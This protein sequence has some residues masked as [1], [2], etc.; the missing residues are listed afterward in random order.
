MAWILICGIAGY[1]FSEAAMALYKSPLAA[2]PLWGRLLAGLIYWPTAALFLYGLCL[3]PIILMVRKA[4]SGTTW[5]D[6]L[7]SHCLELGV[8]LFAVM[9]MAL[10]AGGLLDY[11]PGLVATAIFKFFHYCGESNARE[12]DRLIKRHAPRLRYDSQE[13]ENSYPGRPGKNRAIPGPGQARW[14]FEQGRGT[15]WKK[16]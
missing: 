5:L 12:L 15:Q 1:I 8:F 9:P 6:A 11:W 10:G 7:G 3:R 2:H 14:T 13:P 16:R 4:N